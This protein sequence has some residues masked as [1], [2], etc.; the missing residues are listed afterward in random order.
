MTRDTT[1][2]TFTGRHMAIIMAAFFA[3]VF[4]VNF[5]M[6]YLASASWT[7][8]VV[9]NS[10]VAS[11]RFNAETARREQRQAAGVTSHVRYG[12]GMLH[13]TFVATPGER[14]TARSVRVMLGRPSHAGEDVTLDLPQ[15]SPGTFAAAAILSRGVWSGEVSAEIGGDADWR[16]PIRF[17]VKDP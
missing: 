13:L 3:V 12:A 14:I 8:L 15:I 6:A 4:A 5:T 7:G 9:A 10:Y 17:T 1:A 2:G 11:Q 16:Q